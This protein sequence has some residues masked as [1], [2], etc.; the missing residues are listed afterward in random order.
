MVLFG[1]GGE[2]TL[3]SLLP[4][5]FTPVVVG[6]A[7][8]GTDQAVEVEGPQAQRVLANEGALGQ[9]HGWAFVGETGGPGGEGDVEGVQQA[10]RAQDVVLV[11]REV[12]QGAGDQSGEVV[13][14]VAGLRSAAA[15][16]EL[17]EPG[18]GQIEM[19]EADRA[20]VW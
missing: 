9:P 11:G 19:E 1:K 17:Q 7:Y 14:E 4:V 18:D 2:G 3:R 6:V 12:G 16:A 10:H 13:V 8:G 20:S 5:A 15:A